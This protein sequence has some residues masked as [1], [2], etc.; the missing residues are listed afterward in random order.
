M[1]KI[2]PTPV[3][4]GVALAAVTLGCGDDRGD[5]MGDEGFGEADG[6]LPPEP[7]GEGDGEPVGDGDGDGEVEPRECEVWKIAYDLTGSK[8]EISDTPLNLGNQTNVVGEPYD[9]YDR[10][11]PGKF[12]LHFRDLDGTPGER[13]FMHAY[14]MTLN[15]E[16]RSP[17]ASVATNLQGSAGPAECG[18]T[19][20]ALLGS[21]VAWM[22]AAIVGY[23]SR[24]Q[25][26]CRGAFCGQADL[27]R[28]EAVAVDEISDQPLGEFVFSEGL[29]RFTM[30][31]TVIQQDDKSTSSWFFS[32]AEISR[33][34]VPAPDCLCE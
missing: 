17:G 25:L 13:A 10:I 6:D 18:V 9:A 14:E 31:R 21:T 15:F 24:G 28:G 2:S 32:G 3:L 5:P 22:P 23:H 19:S 26:R 4:L 16:V 34:R 8:F 27:P 1:R 20:G 7:E 11:G 33:E 29:R 30:A 12:V